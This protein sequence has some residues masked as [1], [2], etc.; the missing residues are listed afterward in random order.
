[1]TKLIARH[2]MESASGRA[3][4]VDELRNSMGTGWFELRTGRRSSGWTKHGSPSRDTPIFYGRR[5]LSMPALA[6][7]ADPAER[8]KGGANIA[9]G[10]NQGVDQVHVQV[11]RNPADAREGQLVGLAGLGVA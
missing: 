9:S 2:V 6:L 7:A 10:D 5:R 1:M 11:G 8:P 4:L 3:Y